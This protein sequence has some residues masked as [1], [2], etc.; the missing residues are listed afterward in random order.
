MEL[1]VWYDATGR[2]SGFQI[3]YVI[4]GQ[5]E[6]ALTWRPGGGFSHALVDTG[7]SRPDKN[8]TPILVPDGAVPWAMLAREFG[9]RGA[10][11]EPALRDRVTGLLQ[12][13]R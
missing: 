9:L 1:I 8:L 11:L 12:E 13:K 4:P 3:C 7:D 2:M 10:D 6:R 5:K